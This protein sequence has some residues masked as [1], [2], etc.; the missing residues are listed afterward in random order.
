MNQQ[1]I[2]IHIE[3]DGPTAWSAV[4]ALKGPTDY[5]L[6]QLYGGHPVYGNTALLYIGLAADQYLGQRIPQDR[7]WL[8]EN[9]DAGRVDVYLGR[10]S[11]SKTPDDNT[12]CRQ[13]RLAERLLIYAHSPPMN[14]Q[15]NLGRLEPDLH[16]VRVLNWGKHRDLLP[17]VSGARWTSRYD[18]IPNFHAFSAKEIPK[19]RPRGMRP[20]IAK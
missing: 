7:Q 1:E 15:K 8:L 11:G 9:R 4:T 6:Y 3:W 5:G 17:E 18:N 14:N 12:W 13:I 2:T 16:F 20:S 10:L 19:S